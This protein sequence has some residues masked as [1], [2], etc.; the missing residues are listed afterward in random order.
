MRA[1]RSRVNII[2]MSVDVTP[3]RENGPRRVSRRITGLYSP[4]FI[5]RRSMEA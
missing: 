3:A 1:V 4:L 5:E 2:K